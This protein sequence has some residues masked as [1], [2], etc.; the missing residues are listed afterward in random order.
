M[1]NFSCSSKGTSFN[2]FFATCTNEK[3]QSSCMTQATKD[4]L[5]QY[6]EEFKRN[7]EGI[8]HDQLLEFEKQLDVLRATK[9]AQVTMLDNQLDNNS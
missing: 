1:G 8:L 3:C 9:L 6:E 5:K 4:A 2:S 7:L